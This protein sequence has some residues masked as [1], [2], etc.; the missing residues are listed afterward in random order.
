[1]VVHVVVDISR[2]QFHSINSSTRHIYELTVWLD[3]VERVLERR[4]EMAV[5]F[6]FSRRSIVFKKRQMK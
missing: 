4:A 3:A 2:L 1:M 5:L 6:R